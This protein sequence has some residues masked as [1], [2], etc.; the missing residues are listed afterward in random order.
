M[1]KVIILIILNTSLTYLIISSFVWFGLFVFLFCFSSIL[2][3]FHDTSHYVFIC[4]VLIVRFLSCLCYILPSSGM[5]KTECFSSLRDLVRLTGRKNSRIK[6]P[7]K[8]EIVISRFFTHFN[9][10]TG[11]ALPFRDLDQP[12]R[13]IAYFASVARKMRT[14][15]EILQPASVVSQTG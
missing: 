11:V 2:S 12:T 4:F 3:S 5:E 14:G 9:V 7:F 10:V 15:S 1:F 8:D 13:N 6:K